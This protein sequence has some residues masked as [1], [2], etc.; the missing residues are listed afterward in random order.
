MQLWNINYLK[1]LYN[2]YYKLSVETDDADLALEYQSTANSVLNVIDRYDEMTKKNSK[3]TGAFEVGSYK[4]IISD[5]FSTIQ[6]Y[7]TYCPYIRT[8]GN[9]EDLLIMKPNANLPNTKFNPD[10][11]LMV[12]DGFFSLIGGTFAETYQRMRR[13][14][15]D[16][17]HLRHIVGNEDAAGQTYSIY[18]TD[19]V[20]FE[21]GFCH[22][23]QDY[24]SAIHEFGHGISCNLNNNR[25][26]NFGAYCFIEVDSLFFEMLGNEY[27]GEVLNRQKDAFDVS[28]I[29]LRDYLYTSKLLS[30]KLDAY[31]TLDRITINDKRLFRKYL[32]KEVGLDKIAVDDMVT[33]SFRENMHYI[34]S[35]LTAIELYLMYQSDPTRALDILFQIINEKNEDNKIYLENVRKLGIEPG[36]NFECYINILLEKAKG[37]N[38]EKSLRYKNE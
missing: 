22:T 23:A 24:V 5:D 4:S 18:N 17:I 14:F 28:I 10:E 25:M 29:V 2:K 19:I 7:G 37:V 33:I 1:D 8:L 26:Y 21:I 13:S 3:I 34:I 31:S 20:F 35:Y 11:M 9:Y 27:A 16:T 30:L 15:K 12:S 32:K 36:K 38:D 6:K